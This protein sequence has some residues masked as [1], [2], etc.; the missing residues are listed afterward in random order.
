[1]RP[2]ELAVLT[3]LLACGCAT[4]QF[5]GRGATAPGLDD[6]HPSEAGVASSALQDADVESE[7]LA[8]PVLFRP[9]QTFALIYGFG[10]PNAVPMGFVFAESGRHPGQQLIRWYLVKGMSFAD[11]NLTVLPADETLLGAPVPTS[12][13]AFADFVRTRFDADNGDVYIKSHADTYCEKYTAKAGAREK[14]VVP[15]PIPLGRN[16][17]DP[18][19]HKKGKSGAAA[20]LTGR[21]Q[22]IDGGTVGIRPPQPGGGGP[23]PPGPGGYL[24][25][26]L[27]VPK[28][29]VGFALG[30]PMRASNKEVW[31]LPDELFKTGLVGT[32]CGPYRAA[33]M[34]GEGAVAAD[35]AVVVLSSSHYRHSIPNNG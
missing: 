35:W 1:M 24:D 7:R 23:S 12:G 11:E 33:P 30:G 31:I 10:T 6:A 14:S 5:S 2:R 32:T 25:P 15:V 13:R 16:P 4:S 28:G 17:P 19:G 3:C 34:L 29:V 9:G 22:E 27:L 21:Y 8:E 18:P 20:S 26:S